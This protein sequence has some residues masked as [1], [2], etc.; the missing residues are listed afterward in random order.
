MNKLTAIL[1]S[2]LHL[3]HHDLQ[4]AVAVKSETMGWSLQRHQVHA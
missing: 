4:L 2:R 1:S 3:R